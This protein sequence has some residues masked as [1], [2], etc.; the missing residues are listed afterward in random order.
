[1]AAESPK[2]PKKPDV[3][4]P[5]IGKEERPDLTIDLNKKVGDL[6]VRDLQTLLG[7]G[8]SATVKQ[9]L[10]ETVID[11][12]PITD[13][14]F[15]DTT[16]DNKDLKD[17]KDNKDQKDTKDHKDPKDTK[18]H[19]D[20]KDTKDHKDPKDTKDHKDNKDQKDWKDKDKDK[21]HKEIVKDV[22]IEKLPIK[23]N[24]EK[25][26]DGPTGPGPEDPGAIPGL[27]D[28]IRRLTGLEKDVAEIKGKKIEPPRNP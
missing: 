5:F 20:P 14:V 17:T 25:I 22:L 15:K 8:S 13:K 19:K 24:L 28:I 18:D 11:K 21:D 9:A 7:S 10:K 3:P 6:T 4:E 27:E 1:M 26:P 2:D 16:K 12:S 23:E